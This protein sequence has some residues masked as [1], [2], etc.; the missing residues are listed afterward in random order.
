MKVYS[1]MHNLTAKTERFFF[2]G[3]GR[4]KVGPRHLRKSLSNH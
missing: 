2:A 4:S 1:N 3:G